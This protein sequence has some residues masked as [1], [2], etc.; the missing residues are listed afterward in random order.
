[1]AVTSLEMINTVVEAVVDLVTEEY[2]PLAK[3]AKDVAAGA[4]LVGPGQYWSGCSFSD[5]LWPRR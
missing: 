1:M 2:H 3:I 5:P 4:V